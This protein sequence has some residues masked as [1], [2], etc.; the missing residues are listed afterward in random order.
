VPKYTTHVGEG[1]F[2]IIEGKNGRL[3]VGTA[4]HGQNAYLVEF[5]PNAE[6]MRVV[7]DAMEEIGSDATGFAAQA[8]IHT[9]NNVGRSG[10][11]YFATKQ[12]YPG[13]GE[14]RDD[15]PGGYP[16]VYDPKTGTTRVYDIPVPHQGIISIIPDESRGIAYVST[17]SDE[18]PLDGTRFLVL[19]LETGDY[20]DLGDMHHMYAFI[21]FDQRG[22]ALHPVAGGAIARYDPDRGLLE[23][24]SQTIDGK[25]PPA[26][27]QLADPETQLIFWETSPDHRTLY[28]VPMNGNAV[29]AYDLD[30][31]GA[32]L[33]GRTVGALL[34]DAERV[35]AG[36]VSVS[37]DGQ[38]WVVVSTGWSRE[39]ARL[40]SFTPGEEG[41]VDHGPIGVRN[42]DYTE[43]TD[44]EGKRL[45]AHRGMQHAE[46]GTMIPVYPHGI[47]VSRT[48][49]VYVL[50]L[51]PYTVLKIEPA[52]STPE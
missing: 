35:K 18:R 28:A 13:K 45:P 2:S 48:G 41:V 46:D 15:Y 39:P 1:Y 43:F 20:T 38:L 19:D 5:D 24:L 23:M 49:A 4:K 40:L 25:R 37:P 10:K 50:N 44:E 42:P 7:V 51:R 29:Y 8:K 12:G 11:I 30:G 6:K 17:C 36:G 47:C 16:M 31:S 14:D 9:R 33:R 21:R 34:P 27:S 32:I 22:R 26:E 3:Y 52:G